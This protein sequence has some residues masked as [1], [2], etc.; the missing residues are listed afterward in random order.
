M[1]QIANLQL[2]NS[3]RPEL[4]WVEDF[5]I[6]DVV[7]GKVNDVKDFGVV[8]GF[9]STLMFSALLHTISV[10]PSFENLKNHSNIYYLLGTISPLC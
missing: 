4:K 8:V 1:I 6:G 5:T 10:S 2:S 9:E 7:E 3:T